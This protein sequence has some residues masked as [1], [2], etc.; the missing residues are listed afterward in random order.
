MHRVARSRA[1]AIL[2]AGSLAAA[3]AA[4][5]V[6]TSS[7]PPSSVAPTATPIACDDPVVSG[8]WWD[9]RVFYEIFVRSFADSD[10]DGIGDFR[11]LTERL[12]YLNDGDPGTTDDLGI[13]GIWLMPVFAATSYHGYDVTDYR[14]IDPAYGTDDD[15]RAFVDAA[16][17][18]GID[19]ILDL[20]L[21]HTGVEHPWFAEA[22]DPAS[23]R[24]DWYVWADEFPGYA[25]PGG[26]PIWHAD[27]D[28]WYLGQFWSGMPDLNLRNP[29][30][31]D[32]LVDI[33]R[34]WL[35]GYGA[36]GFR[37]DAIKHLVEDDR[38]LQNTPETIAW[39]EDFNARV[40]AFA[41]DAL[42]VG[43]V[44]DVTRQSARYVPGGVDLAFDFEV[45][46]KILLGARIGEAASL[47]TA[48]RDALA[49]YEDGAYAAFLTNHDQSRVMNELGNIAKARVAAS[50]L[51]TNPGIPFVYY[52]EEIGMAGG[53]PDP[54]IRTPL[55]WTSEA[56][57]FGFTTG[58]P[59]EPFEP[60]W[61]TANVA[62]QRATP[63]SLLAH[64][65]DLV[66][67]RQA[68]PALHRGS[69]FLPLRSTAPTVYAFLVQRAGDAV[70]VV[71]NLG[72]RPAPAAE[73]ALTAGVACPF[74]GATVAYA[75]GFGTTLAPGTA[76]DAPT[77]AM[78][79]SFAGWLPVPEL[80]PLSTLVIALGD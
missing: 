2:L 63:G 74:A 56:P 47:A 35:T 21:N 29:E 26:Q 46:G 16:A 59:W 39:L 17:T 14:R 60:G 27:G 75:D 54:R 28:R 50:A 58:E 19:V 48:Q 44:Y 53:K 33:A 4:D 11:G 72:E 8:R 65:R 52:G 80:P 30:V 49:F 32:E 10:G 37:L 61:E 51:L 18:R 6:T 1:L 23:P 69:T 45:A 9:G 7:A 12:D 41:P 57:G 67:V 36:S 70:A 31:T 22:R 62:G 78:D 42:L 43:E 66:R 20:V 24:A 15:F 55:P 38:T 13:T 77:I 5:P 3:C 76:L 79:G 71:I 68:H 64:Y 34:H 73:L 40:K 25:G